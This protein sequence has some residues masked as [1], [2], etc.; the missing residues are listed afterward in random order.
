V[1]TVRDGKKNFCTAGGESYGNSARKML[2]C[3]ES[4][5]NGRG[6]LTIPAPYRKISVNHSDT[7]LCHRSTVRCPCILL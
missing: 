1:N 3:L 2:Y 6:R 4:G 5:K 7:L